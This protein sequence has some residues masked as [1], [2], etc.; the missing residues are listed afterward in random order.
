[1]MTCLI[2][3]LL[4]VRYCKVRDQAGNK[5][6]IHH[7][8]PECMPGDIYLAHAVTIRCHTDVNT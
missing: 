5:G 7:L 1:M 3:W 2:F 8:R 4:A 6:E